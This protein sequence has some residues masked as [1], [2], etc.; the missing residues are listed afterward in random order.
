MNQLRRY[1]QSDVPSLRYLAPSFAA[2]YSKAIRVRQRKPV[3][4]CCLRSGERVEKDGAEFDRDVQTARAH[5]QGSHEIIST[6]AGNTY[7]HLVYI[8]ACFLEKKT[9]CPMNPQD[10]E[11]GIARKMA[12]VNAPV[13]ILRQEQ[14]TLVPT[15]ENLPLD[16]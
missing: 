7:E 4:V 2:A 9:L 6:I 3:V 10:G 1:H 14:M 8:V 11:V 15:K 12:Q 16:L 5:L 13:T